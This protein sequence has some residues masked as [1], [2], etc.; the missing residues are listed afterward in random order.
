MSQ[1]LSQPLSQPSGST[2]EEEAAV[3]D[4]GVKLT[5]ARAD[6]RAVKSSLD[7]LEGDLD[8]IHTDLGNLMSE[9]KRTRM[10]AAARRIMRAPSP[11]SPASQRAAS[12]TLSSRAKR[13]ARRAGGSQQSTTAEPSPKRARISE[14]MRSAVDNKATYDELNSE[15]T[16]LTF[17]FSDTCDDGLLMW[18]LGDRS[19]LLPVFKKPFSPVALRRMVNV[20]NLVFRHGVTRYLADGSIETRSWLRHP[21]GPLPEYDERDDDEIARVQSEMAEVVMHESNLRAV[22]LF[23]RA[24]AIDTRINE[25]DERLSSWVFD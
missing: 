12:S 7:Y 15:L 23:A 25:L 11:P 1:P 18:Y 16:R 5:F 6:L 9:M 22:E 19:T 14:P 17:S 20:F 3:G 10:S 2:T 8:K 24:R 13:A 21:E 4:I